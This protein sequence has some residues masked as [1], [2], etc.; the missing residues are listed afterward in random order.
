M[1]AVHEKCLKTWMEVSG[2]PIDWAC[3]MKC[4][5]ET[6]L[7]KELSLLAEDE[8]VSSENASTASGSGSHS[9]EVVDDEP[10]DV[11]S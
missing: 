10:H 1:K 11:L 3:P 5:P 7:D 9:V 8:E 6:L 2:K 4:N